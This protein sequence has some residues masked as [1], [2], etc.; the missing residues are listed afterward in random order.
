MKK[1]I[2]LAFVLSGC[3]ASVQM[4]Q[5]NKGVSR[6]EVAAAFKQR[7]DALVGLTK[8]VEQLIAERNAALKAKEPKK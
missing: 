6:E 2:L 3:A 5:S 1:V 7:D 8:A 4:G